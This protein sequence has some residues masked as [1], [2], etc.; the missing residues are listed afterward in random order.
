VYQAG[1][2]DAPP[3]PLN[4][5]NEVWTGDRASS[6]YWSKEEKHANALRDGARGSRS[7]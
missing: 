5:E 1:G 4:H 7:R 3:P 2:G 6:A